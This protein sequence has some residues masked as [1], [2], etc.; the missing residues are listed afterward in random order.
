MIDAVKDYLAPK[1]FGAVAYV[2]LIIHFLCGLVFT[3]LISA[4]RAGE[5][6]EFSCTLD[7]DTLDVEKT[8]YSKYQQI[9]NSPLPLCGFVLLSIGLPVLVSV[10]YSLAVSTRVDKIDDRATT[11]EGDEP[12]IDDEEMNQSF[13]VFYFYFIHLIVRFL[14]GILV[15]ALQYTVFYARG[16]DFEFNCKLPIS[17]KSSQVGDKMSVAKSNTSTTCEN[18]TAS[19]KQL[20]SE[21]VSVLNI[22]VALIILVEMIYIWVR[23]PILNCRSE[24]GWSSDTEFVTVYLLRKGYF[25]IESAPPSM[26]RIADSNT[27]DYSIVDVDISEN[28]IG[29]SN[30]PGQKH[31]DNTTPDSNVPVCSIADSTTPDSSVQ[32][33]NVPGCSIVDSN[34]PDD[35][36]VDSDILENYIG[37]SN[38]PV[39]SIADSSTPDKMIPDRNVPDCSIVDSSTPDNS[40][41]NSDFS[42]NNTADTN[43][44]GCRLADSTTPDKTIPD[45][46]VPDCSIADNTTPDKTIWDSNVPDC[47]IA[48]KATRDNN[49]G[50]NNISGPLRSH[51][52]RTPRNDSPCPYSSNIIPDLDSYCPRSYYTGDAD[53]NTPDNHIKARNHTHT[54]DDDHLC[55]KI[56]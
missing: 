30:I 27:T 39:C 56:L 32:D 9:Y 35:S 16:F 8:C 33:K 36:I 14:L 4:V 21:L 29:D 12:S 53:Y 6:S 50:D 11:N 15:T 42:E 23:F 34:T 25:R 55:C 37:D 47:S 7:L 26:D 48:N 10:S 24:N 46:N 31:S 22:G 45:R 28:N 5:F 20:C 49:T 51:F 2:C 52:R 13:Y 17:D 18:S 54:W 43:V 38:I 44:P 19:E 1:R 3:A 41:A 40:I